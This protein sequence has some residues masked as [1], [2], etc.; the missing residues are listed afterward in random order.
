[1]RPGMES[2]MKGVGFSDRL[3][4]GLMLAVGVASLARAY[5]GLSGEGA[6]IGVSR[7]TGDPASSLFAAAGI[8]CVL[9]ALLFWAGR[10]SAPPPREPTAPLFGRDARM[11]PAGS[12]RLRPIL[13]VV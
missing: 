1:M 6:A 13:L 9:A 3:L 4:A 11:Q 7:L 8:V 12:S 10:L 2:P 5:V